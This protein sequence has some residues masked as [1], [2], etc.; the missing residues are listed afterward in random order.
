MDF[1]NKTILL[2]GGVQGIGKA[3]TESFA[4]C[5]AKI[6]VVDIDQKLGE[7]LITNFKNVEYFNLDL[8]N[9]NQINDY[10]KMINDI[11]IDVFIGNAG[12]LSYKNLSDFNFEDAHQIFNTNLFGHLK[13]IQ[14]IRKQLSRSSLG[15]IILMSSINGDYG[16]EN[17]LFY[18]L[19]KASIN[20]AIKSLCVDLSGENI[21]VNGIAPGFIKT[22]MSV[23]ADGSDEFENDNFKNIYIKNKKIPIGRYGTPEDISKVVLFLASSLSN[24]INGQI[25]NVDGGVTSTF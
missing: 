20:N 12:I 24:Y 19:S 9:Q 7:E 21:T 6:I 3:I 2:T 4:N 5:G 18:N 15:K 1:S 17:S 16:T 25:I 8:S 23:L 14:G 22:R 13:I 10:L 11:S